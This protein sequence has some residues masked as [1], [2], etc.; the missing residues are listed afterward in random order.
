MTRYLRNSHPDIRGS[1]GER[2]GFCMISISGGLKL[3]AVAGRPSVTRLTHSNWTGISAS[4]M[5]RA[6]VRKI[7]RKSIDVNNPMII[8]WCKKNSHSSPYYFPNIRGY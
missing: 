6:A 5:P 2:G 4:G 7:L 1:L 3:R 8:I